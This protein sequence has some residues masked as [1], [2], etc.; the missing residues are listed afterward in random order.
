MR[1]LF[2]LCL[3]ILGVIGSDLQ[4]QY[5]NYIGP[6]SNAEGDYL[7]GVGIAADGLGS[8]NWKSAIGDSILTDTAIRADQYV[9]EVL[10]QDRVRSANIERAK[11][12]RFDA[13][14]N[15][16]LQRIRERP[17]MRDVITGNALN[18]VMEQLN[19]PG[20]TDS[21][22]R[23]AS[24]RVSIEEIRRIPFALSEKG[25]TFSMRQ[26]SAK[27]KGQW[28]VAFQD[29]SF[30]LVRK[31]YERALD[32]ALEH[33]IDRNVPDSV[34]ETYKAAVQAFATK[35]DEKP[36]PPGDKL[37]TEAND[38]IRVMRQITEVLKVK[39]TQDA[40]AELD[41]YGGTTVNDLR[42]FMNGHKLRFGPAQTNEERLL[43]RQLYETLVG[44]RELVVDT[45]K[46]TNQ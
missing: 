8:Y 23:L 36:W 31:G 43:Y 42:K 22:L 2:W 3:L 44:V 5:I 34:I 27:G 12:A 28:E 24:A 39:G 33:M 41:S 32:S 30:A 21:A 7:R 19:D 20:I 45:G 13:N 1:P 15:A 35:L 4:A 16:I 14:F 29:P 18:A 17:E 25:V 6:G 10:R 46:G 40:L 37:R 11:Q 38:R 26:L 9:R